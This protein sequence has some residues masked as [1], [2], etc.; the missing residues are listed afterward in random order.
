MAK[1]MAELD[2]KPTKD[3]LDL[4]YGNLIFVGIL[5]TIGLVDS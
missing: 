5:T 2:I 3:Y 1:L 4:H